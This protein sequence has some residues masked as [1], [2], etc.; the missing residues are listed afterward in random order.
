VYILTARALP[1]RH[2]GQVTSN[3]RP[4]NPTTSLLQP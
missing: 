3:V 1:V 2:G 4:H